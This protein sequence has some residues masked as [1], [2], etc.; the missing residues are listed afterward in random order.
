M[1]KGLGA[2]TQEIDAPFDPEP[3]APHGH[4]HAHE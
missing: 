1:V 3:A 2:V 4:H